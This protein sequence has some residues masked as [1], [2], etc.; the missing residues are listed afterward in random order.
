MMLIHNHTTI[1]SGHCHRW[2]F[3][4]PRRAQARREL[5]RLRLRLRQTRQ[6]DLSESGEGKGDLKRMGAGLVMHAQVPQ[7]CQRDMLSHSDPAIRNSGRRHGSRYRRTPADDG[8]RLAV[9]QMPFHGSYFPY[10]RS[11]AKCRMGTLRFIRARGALRASPGGRSQLTPTWLGR[12]VP[13]KPLGPSLISVRADDRN[14]V[15]AL[16]KQGLLA[17]WDESNER[18]V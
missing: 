6:M 9:A 15:T 2:S 16:G 11:R 8:T 4:S 14:A 12:A 7:H 3:P 13:Q 5:T 18:G 10:P 1:G 17:G